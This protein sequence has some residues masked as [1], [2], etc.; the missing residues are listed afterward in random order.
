MYSPRP[1]RYGT[2]YDN[3]QLRDTLSSP[4]ISI[5]LPQGKGP[6]NGGANALAA[7]GG[8]SVASIAFWCQNATCKGYPLTPMPPAGGNFLAGLPKGLSKP[9]DKVVRRYTR[10]LSLLTILSKAVVCGL[11]AKLPKVHYIANR[12]RNT[13][14]PVFVLCTG[15]SKV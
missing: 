12:V 5:T 14:G 4:R 6:A 7:P 10:P 3:N 13:A 2:P 15:S 8:E 9:F 11:L 1:G